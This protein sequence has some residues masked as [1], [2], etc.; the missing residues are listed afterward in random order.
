M[1]LFSALLCSVPAHPES[2]NNPLA[3]IFLQT[4]DEKTQAEQLHAF[5]LKDALLEQ[6]DPDAPI[7]ESIND[8][9]LITSF[10]IHSML[11]IVD[12]KTTTFFA[13]TACEDMLSNPSCTV[14]QIAR[15]KEAIALFLA[16]DDQIITRLKTIFSA[17]LTTER[18]IISPEEDILSKWMEIHKE[19]ASFFQSWKSNLAQSL[20]TNFGYTAMGTGFYYTKE[21]V[22][23]TGKYILSCLPWTT[24]TAPAAAAAVTTWSELFGMAVSTSAATTGLSLFGA[25]AA[26]TLPRLWSRLFSP[27]DTDICETIQEFTHHL[28]NIADELVRS[29]DTSSPNPI[30]TELIMPILEIK[31]NVIKDPAYALSII[32]AMYAV[33]QIDVYI[34]LADLVRSKNAQFALVKMAPGKGSISKNYGEKMLTIFQPT[35][36][37]TQGKNHTGVTITSADGA[38]HFSLPVPQTQAMATN[39]IA[40]VLSLFHVHYI[41]QALGIVPIECADIMFM[42]LNFHDMSLEMRSLSCKGK[43]ILETPT[44][45]N[46]P[47]H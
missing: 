47:T 19:K 1:T 37:S 25:T 44:L 34:T 22:F 3:Q 5:Q 9:N 15:K 18:M 7:Q 38:L 43:I 39:V 13:T 45:I 16:M 8:G 21:A 35:P 11:Q 40:P 29:Q 4:L 33:A 14:E 10:D 27:E 42:P 41:A 12:S 20:V 23:A 24:T 28:L 36:I 46:L 17:M 2:E 32:K 30:L 26:T 6:S 31:P